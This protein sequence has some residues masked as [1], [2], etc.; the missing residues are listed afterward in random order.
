MPRIAPLSPEA[1]PE[2]KESFERYRRS[3]GFV[4][5]SLLIMQRRPKVVRALAQL[6]AAV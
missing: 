2:L 6:A 4:P 3:F 1:T 5:N